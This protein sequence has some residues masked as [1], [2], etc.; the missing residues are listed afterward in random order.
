MKFTELTVYTTSEASELIADVLWRYTNY[1]VAISDVNDVIELQRDKSMY[2]DYMDESLKSSGGEVLVKAFIP[3]EKSQKLIPQIRA[4]IDACRERGKFFVKFGTLEI[5]KR[6]VEGDD[7][8]EIWRK[9]FRPIHLSDRIVICPE[10]IKYEPQKGERV[11]KI[12]SN[13]AFGTGEHETTSMCLKLI[14][15]YL[16]PES[17]CIDVGCG[18]GIL[19]I[20]AIKLGARKAYLTDIDEIAVQ[21]ALHNAKV[22]GVEDKVTVSHSD[23]LNNADIKGDIICANITGEILCRL[24][25]SIPKN[26]LRDGVLILSGIIQSRLNMVIEAFEAQGLKIDRRMREGEWY[27]LALRL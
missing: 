13:M 6:L 4:D 18:S 25:P 20:A 15:S 11:I 3:L 22:N 27:A 5:T 26:M 24:A 21:S 16:T 14:E 7:W 17:V 12:D 2:W 23:L 10:W 9:H 1:G 19:G 8:L